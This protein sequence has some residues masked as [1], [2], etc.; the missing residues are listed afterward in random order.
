MSN[1]TEE[2]E[3]ARSANV[4]YEDD[5]TRVF[6]VNT[7][8]TINDDLEKRETA[9]LV[10]NG[11]TYTQSY[12]YNQRKG[13]NYA[14]PKSK[15]DDREV[16]TGIVH[17]KIVSFV[18]IFLKY[19]F[20][21]HIKAYQDGELVPRLGDVYELGIE[22]SRKIENFKR[23]IALIYWEMFTQGDCF[24]LEDWQVRNKTP[25]IPMKDGVD[26]DPEEMDYTY[27]YLE[28]ITYRDGEMIQERKAES[29]ILDGRQVILGDPEI[30]S[31]IQDQ[32]HIT[33]E[34]KMSREEAKA[35][36]DKLT[37]W[38]KV[39]A[40][41]EQLAAMGFDD[42]NTLFS[43]GRLEDPKKQ[44]LVHRFFDKECNKFN[45]F[46]N[47]TMM[48]PMKTPFTLFYPRGNYPITQFS[49]ERL[50]GSSYSRSVPAKTKF[51]ADF[52]DW[53]LKMLALKFEQGIE[54]AILAQGKYTLTRDMFRA[55]KVTHG[56]SSKDY[57][58]ADPDNKGVTNSEFSFFGLL[59][60]LI[61]AQTVNQTTSGEMSANATAT[62]IAITDQNQQKKL[63]YLLDGMILGFFDLDMRRCETLES[64]YTRKQKETV[65]NGKTISV[66]QDFSISIAGVQNIVTF[67]DELAELEEDGEEVKKKR[68][69]LFKEAHKSKKDGNHTE[70]YLVDPSVI[71]SGDLVLDLEI[72]PEQMKD[73]QIQMIQMFDEFN[74]I[75][76]IFGRS[77]QGGTTDIAEMQKEYLQVSGRSEDFF[78]SQDLIQQ[79]PEL[80]AALSENS[81][82]GYNTGS[83]GKPSVKAA[84][85]NKAVG[86]PA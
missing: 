86:A 64:K 20:K 18:A 85:R 52:L 55:G 25:Q 69:E 33:I 13:I 19:V 74:Q 84:L 9:S 36:F 75:L 56:V 65:V 43:S 26:L 61:E 40:S 35:M 67:S 47:G 7:I 73:S 66:Y 27:E 49:A 70:R 5:E 81:G 3:N 46:V 59:K 30:D 29:V 53:A 50:T 62:E 10:F 48:L 76:S 77:D 83:F 58:K 37:M 31:G 42:K 22:F 71:R 80:A 72:R 16:S 12:E 2:S 11:L 28:G 1:A 51:N 38:A 34:E 24:V 78:I 8:Q 6:A 45:F 32:P 41:K 68:N 82:G 39:P 14:P 60:E 4:E 21:R 79:D 17:E 15:K 63:S 57:E 44:V 54:P 23:K